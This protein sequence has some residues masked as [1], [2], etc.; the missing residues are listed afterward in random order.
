MKRLVILMPGIFN[1]LKLNKKG[2][3]MIEASITVPLIIIITFL[4]IRLT[5]FYYEIMNTRVEMHE[6]IM[7]DALATDELVGE[8]IE[9]NEKIC[10]IDNE[11]LN[12]IFEFNVYS[13]YH[14]FSETNLV[15][16][17]DM[18]E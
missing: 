3:E 15:M 16:V 10:L 9:K 2:E 17:G 18:I 7:E 14:V 11:Y 12:K 6:N 13:T 1:K 8:A 4:L 5:I